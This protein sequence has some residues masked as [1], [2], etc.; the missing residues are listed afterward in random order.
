MTINWWTG[1]QNVAYPNNGNLAI[2]R[3][4][5]ILKSPSFLN[6]RKISVVI[7]MKKENWKLTLDN[8]R[9]LKTLIWETFF[10][11]SPTHYPLHHWPLEKHF[12]I[13]VTQCR[14]SLSFSCMI[15]F[16]QLSTWGGLALILSLSSYLCFSVLIAC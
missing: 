16:I 14:S 4:V 8:C 10:I 12:F 5:K 9:C 1:K 3:A 2:K 13:S 7:E 15:L 11:H 6:T